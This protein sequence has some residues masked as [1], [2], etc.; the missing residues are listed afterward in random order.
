M[1]DV[2]PAVA[3]GI[4]V[5][6]PVGTSNNS[7][8]TALITFAHPAQDGDIQVV[9][10]GMQTGT[11]P[12]ELTNDRSMSRVGM[13]FVANDTTVRYHAQWMLG[14]PSAASM[15]ATVQFGPTTAG[16]R[17]V[18]IN[19]ILR[20]ADLT[21]LNGYST[22]YASTGTTARSIT[23]ITPTANGKAI[24]SF[25][26]TWASPNDHAVATPPAGWNLIMS[27]VEP[28][29][30]TSAVSRNTVH[31]YE[32]DVAAG[33]STGACT[34]TYVGTP[35]QATGQMVI[36][37]SATV[38][39]TVPSQVTGLTVVQA[40]TGT[41]GLS[42]TAPFNGGQPITGYKIERA[43]DAAGAP[44]T[45]ANLVANTANTATTY[46]DATATVGT[47]WY[48]VSAI[49]MFGPGPASTAVSV[50]IAAASLYPVVVDSTI[51]VVSSNTIQLPSIP[52]PA[53]TDG[54]YIV[55]VIHNQTSADTADYTNTQGFTHIGLPWSP[56]GTA[57]RYLGFWGCRVTTAATFPT[58]IVFTRQAG[59]AGARQEAICFVVNNV[60]PV[61]PVG[62]W[63]ATM[64]TTGMPSII[65]NGIV[66]P[67]P[68]HLLLAAFGG[69]WSSPYPSNVTTDPAG[70]T[71]VAS[72][73]EAPA[74]DTTVSRNRLNV[75]RENRDAGATDN[76]L[77]VYD[78]SSAA[79]GGLLLSLRAVGSTDVSVGLQFWE[80]TGTA[81]AGPLTT[82]EAT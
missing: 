5:V 74:A 19:F 13:A 7:T 27:Y 54:C 25:A 18:G 78:G 53:L 75:Y 51:T 17:K 44:G 71:L 72:R 68:H 9:V 23:A 65:A 24:A 52:T 33:V 37:K 30:G 6:A 34:L 28:V 56:P 29:G 81:W 48:R 3:S 21:T 31:V 57:G 2:S 1:S 59:A 62:A 43:P 32:T 41:A 36:F 63:S 82:Q 76:R 15:P 50:V 16:S 35:A 22:A 70:M 26:A 11:Q 64:N 61:K 77:A 58:S 55:V 80:W 40:G 45:W 66:V 47:W 79:R 67:G 12:T 20:G 60:D 8:T 42:W 69:V 14:V 10:W 73:L 38:A 46:S 4:T 39:S 49:N